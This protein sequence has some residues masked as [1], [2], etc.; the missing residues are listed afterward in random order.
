MSA[1]SAWTRG[2]GE[3]QLDLKASPQGL[4]A[5]KTN[6][7]GRKESYFG[8]YSVEGD[9]LKWCVSRKERPTTFESTKGQFLLILKREA[10]K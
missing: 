5:S 1:R 10:A 2:W 6:A 9:T 7:R 4:D 8:I 3:Y